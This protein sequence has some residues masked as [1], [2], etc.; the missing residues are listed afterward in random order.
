M[1]IKPKATNQ[2]TDQS[3]DQSTEQPT[4]QPI[5]SDTPKKIAIKTTIKPKAA[6]SGGDGDTDTNYSYVGKTIGDTYKSKELRE[7]IYSD[8]DTYAGSIDAQEE[9]VYYYSEEDKRM[10]FGKVSFMECFYKL[11]DEILVNAI[12][13][14]HRVAG[15]IRDGHD[16]KPVTRISVTIDEVTGLIT[17]ENDGTGI[18]VV[19]H[20]TKGIYI[21]QFLFGDLLTSINYTGEEEQRTVG[22]K[23]GYGAKIT[24]IFSKEFTVETIDN[25]RGLHYKQ[26]WHDNMQIC[27]EPIITSTKRVPY[28]KFTYMPDYARFKV[29]D[30]STM[31][32]W[33]VLKKR[34]YD[35]AACTEA[36]CS[37]YLNGTK[38]EA[39]T[40]EDYINLYIGKKSET[41]RV[42]AELNDFWQVGVCLSPD[43]EGRQI[44]FVNGICTDRGGRHVNHILDNLAKKIIESISDKDKKSLTIEPKFI[45]QNL[46]V[47]IRSTIYNPK[48]DTQTKRKLVTL[49]KDFGRRCELPDEFVKSVIKLGILERAKKLAEFK[50]RENLGKKTDGHGGGRIFHPKLT[51]AAHECIKKEP[52]K[53]TIV[54]TE[55]DSAATF[56]SHGIK[57][58]PDEERNYWGWFPL[59]GKMLNVRTATLKQLA[60]NEELKMIKKITGLREK[61]DYSIPANRK[62]LRYGRFAICSDPDT[63]GDHIR[64]LF[65]NFIMTYWPE[66]LKV[67]GFI[68]SIA[69]PIIK[70]SKR[71]SSGYKKKGKDGKNN[72]LEFYSMTEYKTWAERNN[73]G[74]GWHPKYYKG[75]G[76]FEPKECQELCK[77]MK[78][79]EYY[80][81]DDVIDYKGK[82]V[83]HCD[84]KL[85]MAFAKKM[86]SDRKDWL[87]H[88]APSDD[89][90]KITGRSIKIPYHEFI[91]RRLKLFSV[92]DNVRSIPSLVDGFKPGQRKIIYAAHQKGLKEETKLVQLGGSVNEVAGYHHGETALYETII[93]LAA[94]YVGT[95]NMQ[96]LYPAGQFGSR[97]GAGPKNTKGKDA[98]SP[99]YIS[100]MFT[101]LA[102]LL[103]N[104]MDEP[105]L[106]HNIDDGKK[107]EPVYYVP[108]YPLVLDGGSGIGTGYSYETQVYNPLEVIRNSRALV[109]GEPLID[110]HPWYRGYRGRVIPLGK[111][112]YVTVGDWSRTGTNTITIYELPVGAKKCKSFNQYKEFLSTLLD[113]ETARARGIEVAKKGARRKKGDDEASE[114]EKEKER[115]EASDISVSFKTPVL[116]DYDIIKCDGTDFIV[117]I[118]F[119][120]GIL[121]RELAD[122]QNYRFEKKMKL[123]HAFSTNNMFLYSPSGEL[124]KYAT[125][126]DILREFAKVRLDYN[127]K[128]REYWLKKYRFD[129]GRA[130][131]RY[132][133][134]K[135]SMDGPDRKLFIQ[136]KKKAEAELLIEAREYP[137]YAAKV[138][139]DDDPDKKNY[140]YLLHMHILSYTEEA[141][142]KLLKEQQHFEDLFTKMETATPESLWLDDLGALEQAYLKYN[143]DWADRNGVTMTTRVKLSLKKKEVPK[144]QPIHKEE[145]DETPEMEEDVVD[146]EEG[147]DGEGVDEDGE[148]GEDGV[149]EAVPLT[150]KKIAKV[151]IKIR[152]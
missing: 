56:M 28:T 124:E 100:T 42:F 29:S 99:R 112:K 96:M 121:D 147:V 53:C 70:L 68:C 138:E 66:L 47:F 107:V 18:D 85:T 134:I 54:F 37:I 136:S 127:A 90:L 43:G 63:D 144:A 44:S 76:T 129:Y 93:G 40:F 152:S 151:T 58:L 69:V 78:L 126:N 38:I 104:A 77:N 98:A 31:S 57:G 60:E 137:K 135:E 86:E 139:D 82:E 55:G 83:N 39:K 15:L 4:E 46:C 64:G 130:S 102:P 25:K 27:D 71:D 142:E 61:V 1:S 123:A 119:K 118:T 81:T 52:Q 10:V 41:K 106:V 84:F 14:H 116:Q 79:M 94:D 16:C 21:P 128:R 67:P 91:D 17:V 122:N 88:G 105:L 34:V 114:K 115:D 12:D 48:F 2:S 103:I 145:V 117:A 92:A 120:D 80:W 73:G 148:D 30:P 109:R 89:M 6:P 87:K 146:G 36:T 26:T 35:A 101:T 141:L 108:T 13:Q 75:L 32:D 62:H 133:F 3:T 19:L 143:E 74:K 111:G 5:A 59:R 72:E 50:A 125:P 150:P 11:F 140:D 95:G 33:K 45:K 131:A 9:E 8:P 132:R 22:G 149:V 24:N 110:L 51:D 97:V 65:M 49:V 7:H 23:N 20:P 113:E